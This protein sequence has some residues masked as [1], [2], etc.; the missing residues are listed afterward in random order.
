[1]RPIKR[2]RQS[3]FA[4]YVRTWDIRTYTVLSRHIQKNTVFSHVAKRLTP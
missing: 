2:F 1:M 3:Y 4:V